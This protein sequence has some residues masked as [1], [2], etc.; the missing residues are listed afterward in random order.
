MQ[1]AELF[2]NAGDLDVQQNFLI[3]PK[4]FNEEDKE[5]LLSVLC[6]KFNESYS[7]D[8]EKAKYIERELE[9]NKEYPNPLKRKYFSPW[10]YAR[11]KKGSIVFRYGYDGRKES[12]SGRTQYTMEGSFFENIDL[13]K[14]IR[15]YEKADRNILY[16]ITNALPESMEAI[17]VASKEDLFEKMKRIYTIENKLDSLFNHFYIG[18]EGEEFPVT[19]EMNVSKLYEYDFFGKCAYTRKRIK[20]RIKNS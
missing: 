10:Y 5:E 2:F 4:S 16:E 8:I 3:Y 17:L 1:E 13:E 15:I 7:Y 6:T 12:G 11:V 18:L 19:I 14:T 9:R 20:E